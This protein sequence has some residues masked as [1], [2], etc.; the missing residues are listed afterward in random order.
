VRRALAAAAAI[1]V[2]MTGVSAAAEPIPRGKLSGQT[3]AGDVFGLRVDSKGRVYSV[4]YEGITLKC[5]D[6]TTFDT[7]SRQKPDSF[8]DTEVRTQRSIRFTLDAKRRWSFPARNDAAGSGYDI[9]GRFKAS[10]DRATGTVRV[11]AR[12]DEQNNP[13]PGGPV[14]CDSGKLK[15][16]VTRG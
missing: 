13:D 5:T 7:P 8:G 1:A 2:S 14:F 12:F 6:G 11:F 3:T 4:H 15:W 16:A 9:K 10:G